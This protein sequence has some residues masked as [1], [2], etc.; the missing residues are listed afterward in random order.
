MKWIFIMVMAHKWV[1]IQTRLDLWN[2]NGMSMFRK[3]DN[4]VLEWEVIQLLSAKKASM[5]PPFSP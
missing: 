1:T 2:K 5:V 3:G 4:L